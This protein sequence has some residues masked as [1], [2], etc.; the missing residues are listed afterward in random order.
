MQGTGDTIE[1][2]EVI[3]TLARR[4][5][6]L[7]GG[8]LFGI[9]AAL[10]LSLLL[11][12]RYQAGS[13]ILLRNGAESGGIPLPGMGGL[14][15]LLPRSMQSGFDTELEV[16]MS[17]TGIEAVID[18]LLLQARVVRPHRYA[19]RDLFSAGSFESHLQPAT[20]RFTR[21]GDGYRVSG[22][23]GTVRARPGVPF[24]LPGARL[25]LAS[26]TLPEEFRIRLLPRPEVVR[27]ISGALEAGNPGGDVAELVYRAN[28]AATA[29]AVPNTLVS[30]YM[31]RRRTTDRGVNQ[32]RYEFLVAR[33][34]SV[35]NQLAEAEEALRRT[36]EASGVFD[37]ELYAKADLERAAMLRAELEGLTMESQALSRIVQAG[38]DGTISPRDLAAYPTF[39]RNEAINELLSRLLEQEQERLEMLERRTLVD[40]DVLAFDERIAQL[41]GQLVS[42]S[43]AYLNGL[44]EQGEQIRREL[45]GYERSLAE[46][47]GIAQ[48]ALRAFREV[49]RLSEISL[50]LHAQL[51]EARLDAIREGGEIREIDPAVPPHKPAFPNLPLNLVI[52][53]FGGLFLGVIG[54]FGRNLV[55]E[56]IDHPRDAELV[57]GIPAILFR[58]GAPL[59][60]ANAGGK[61]GVLVVPIGARANGADPVA[62]HIAA[63][64]ALQGS[65]VALAALRPKGAM[66]ESVRPIGAGA[67]P[68][69]AGPL[70]DAAEADVEQG[71][72][73]SAR[74]PRSQATSDAGRAP[75]YVASEALVPV[76]Q[77][78]ERAPEHVVSETLV[79]AQQG[80]ERASEHAASEALVR[81]E[82]ANDYLVYRGREEAGEAGLTPA[83]ARAAVRQLETQLRLVIAEVPPLDH[84]ITTAL[85]SP[86]RP[87]VLVGRLGG[88]T[89]SE[90]R[91]TIDGLARAGVP[92]MGI[93]LMSSEPNARDQRGSGSARLGR[94]GGEGADEGGSRS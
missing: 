51:L 44:A 40:P 79:P 75:E 37:P 2:R 35:Q 18:S 31:H 24:E 56:R 57:A 14:G 87:V 22:P 9:G 1:V 20:Y 30:F 10:A 78:A 45:A 6:W 58:S 76:K 49:E 83:Q 29:A 60:L 15:S 73:H 36:Q 11:P 59:L 34:D 48:S 7:L 26:G 16:L 82:E 88:V 33:V 25:T 70:V 55:S 62:G 77:D 94:R 66:P 19:T 74:D 23:D 84:P 53:L 71:A 91:E 41:E 47:P 85:L 54:A 46:V 89:R 67:Q 39:L 28:D 72:G 90:L 80:A 21:D 69:G 93:V 61:R 32:Q 43:T 5:R 63:T 3:G 8:A 81:L 52:G 65:E 86:E 38:I 68:A 42:L 27:G 92:T 64:A 4:W 12:P 17:R 50:V 13:K